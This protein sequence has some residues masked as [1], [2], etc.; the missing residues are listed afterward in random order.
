MKA[1]ISPNQCPTGQFLSF[2]LLF[3]LVPSF[4]FYA[5]HVA[6]NTPIQRRQLVGMM[7]GVAQ[8]Q[9]SDLVK[10][11]SHLRTPETIQAQG[12]T[13]SRFFQALAATALTLGWA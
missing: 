11:I 13:R 7:S 3:L 5:V 9:A 8:G 10:L 2:A 12:D 4:T 6:L 1:Q